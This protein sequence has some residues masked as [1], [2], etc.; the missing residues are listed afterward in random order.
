MRGFY[1]EK[2]RVLLMMGGDM[3]FQR[4]GREEDGFNRAVDSSRGHNV[5]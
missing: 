3:L 5:V 1:R 2:Q 4:N